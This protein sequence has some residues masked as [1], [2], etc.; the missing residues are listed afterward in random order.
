MKS[1]K[2]MR[3]GKCDKCNCGKRGGAYGGSSALAGSPLTMKGG[4]KKS[5]KKLEIKNSPLKLKIS[6]SSYQKKLGYI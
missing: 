1:G 6:A 5:M 3:G 2:L 4:A